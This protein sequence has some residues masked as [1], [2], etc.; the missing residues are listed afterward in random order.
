LEK[1][2]EEEK[3]EVEEAVKAS[4]PKAK[5]VTVKENGDVEIEYEDG[6]KNNLSGEKT[7]VE[8]SD[9]EKYPVVEPDKVKVNNKKEL[10]S[11][12]KKEVE[13]PV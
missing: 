3:K 7:V 6:S 8:K 4:N 1:L 2:S 12:E 11:E 10:S 5:T 13:E 9:K